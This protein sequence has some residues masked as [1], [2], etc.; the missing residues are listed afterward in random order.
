MVKLLD[1]LKVKALWNRL[2]YREPH[3]FGYVVLHNFLCKTAYSSPE[4][5]ETGSDSDWVPEL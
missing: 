3:K 2:E 1:G 5:S 4:M